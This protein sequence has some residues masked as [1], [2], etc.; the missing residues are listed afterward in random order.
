M[1]E[2]ETKN[3]GTNVDRLTYVVVRTY[4]NPLIASILLNENGSKKVI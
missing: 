4:G 3:L 2:E 1:I